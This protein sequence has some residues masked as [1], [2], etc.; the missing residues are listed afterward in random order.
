[1]VWDLPKK[2]VFDAHGR[3]L[4]GFSVTAVLGP[5]GNTI[6]TGGRFRGELNLTRL[7][8]RAPPDD[9]PGH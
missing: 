7:F 1:V 8:R 5:D 9:P 4:A 2:L 3:W 6:S